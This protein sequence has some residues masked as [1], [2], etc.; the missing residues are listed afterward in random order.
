MRLRMHYQEV[1]TTSE[2]QEVGKNKVIPVLRLVMSIH[3]AATL[4]PLNLQPTRASTLRLSTNIMS[5]KPLQRMIRM[6]PMP[7]RSAEAQKPAHGLLFLRNFVVA[8][9]PAMIRRPKP[10]GTDRATWHVTAALWTYSSRVC[11]W[12]FDLGL[13][14]R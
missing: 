9:V 2:I 5:L 13:F 12:T 6:V 4:D 11:R 8:S 3:V 14:R 10:E 1:S 7:T